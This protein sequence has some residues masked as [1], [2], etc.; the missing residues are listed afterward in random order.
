MSK[1]RAPIW[2]LETFYDFVFNVKKN[3]NKNKRKS[4]EVEWAFVF[5]ILSGTIYSCGQMRTCFFVHR[6]VLFSYKTRYNCLHI[7]K[8]HTNHR[9]KDVISCLPVCSRPNLSNR[10]RTYF[11]FRIR[12]FQTRF[13]LNDHLC[14]FSTTS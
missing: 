8:M 7:S 6:L 2:I 9:N 4:I 13:K 5:G 10:N 14:K 3:K 11:P 12:W 1:L